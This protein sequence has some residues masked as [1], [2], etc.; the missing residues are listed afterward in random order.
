MRLP[1][2]RL[3]ADLEKFTANI[4]VVNDG[5]TDETDLDCCIVFFYYLYKLPRSIKERAGH[6]GQDFK[7]AV[8]LGYR[9]AI[10]IDSDGQ[11]FAKDL[12]V[13]LAKDQGIP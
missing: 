13:F 2:G 1:W 12:P 4:I 7:K 10:T 9:Y 11:H 3:I 8:E 5:S 6:C